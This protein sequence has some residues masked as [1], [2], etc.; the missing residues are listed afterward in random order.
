MERSRLGQFGD[1]E[2]SLSIACGFWHPTAAIGVAGL[3][4]FVVAPAIGTA[5]VGGDDCPIAPS[6]PHDTPGRHVADCGRQPSAPGCA[7]R[8]PQSASRAPIA[9]RI[10]PFLL[11]FAST[12]RRLRIGAA[13]IAIS[14]I[15]QQ[16]Y[17]F[18]LFPDQPQTSVRAAI[19]EATRWS[20]E[21]DPLGFHNGLR[22][23][24]RVAVEADFATKLGATSPADRAVVERVMRNAFAAWQ[25][26]ELR[27]DI[28]LAR[29][30]VEGVESPELGYDIDVFAVP[31]SHPA[32]GGQTYFGIAY[33]HWISP[34]DRLLTNGQ[35]STGLLTLK[36]DIFI[37]IDTVSA[38]TELFSPDRKP[39]ALQRLLTH[40]IG[41]TLG[42]GHPNAFTDL[43]THFDTDLDPHNVMRIDP[44]DPSNQ[45]LFSPNRST[46]AVMSNEREVGRFLF[47]T[48]LQH[49]D[50]GARDVLYPSITRCAADCDGNGEV[51]VVE[52][53]TAVSVALG[54]TEFHRCFRADQDDDGEVQVDELLRGVHAALTGC[55][56]SRL[57]ATSRTARHSPAPG[58]TVHRGVNAVRCR[59]TAPSPRSRVR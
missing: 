30:P 50:R 41:H 57:F 54:E 29:V 51:D 7:L 4:G 36:S 48:E 9:P 38:L 24:L 26:P 17:G 16:A 37:N 21:P 2:E 1:A 13:C 23:G 43:N 32:F 49:D 35:R 39:L 14:L 12:R 40:E 27:F 18:S 11:V 19:E 22:N 6:L 42:F 33:V 52:I 58:A 5:P 47:F 31:A 44:M 56:P 45:L 28:D 15:G 55:P 34:V 3:A 59:A 20:G 53:L 8:L 10:A 25:T 46:E